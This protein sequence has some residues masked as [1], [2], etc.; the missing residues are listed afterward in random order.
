ML[1]RSAIA[2]IPSLTV[3][4]ACNVRNSEEAISPGT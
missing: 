3:A 4:Y 2:W 1:M